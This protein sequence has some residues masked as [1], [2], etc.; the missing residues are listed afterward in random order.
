MPNCH[1]LVAMIPL[2]ATASTKQQIHMKPQ[3]TKN[4]TL[5]ESYILF[6]KIYAFFVS[7]K[8]F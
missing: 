3:E 2:A 4:V 8:Y 6:A 1:V 5:A 7:C